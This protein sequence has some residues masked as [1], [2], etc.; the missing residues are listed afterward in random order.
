MKQVCEMFKCNSKTLILFKYFFLIER[1]GLFRKWFIS[2]PIHLLFN[3]GFML[4]CLSIKCKLPSVDVFA[5]N[6]SMLVKA[7][8]WIVKSFIARKW[9]NLIDSFDAKERL[10]YKVFFYQTGNSGV[11]QQ[12]VTSASTTTSS[13]IFST[14][15]Q[16]ICNV[17]LNVNY[18]GN[19]LPGRANVPGP[20]DCCKYPL[21]I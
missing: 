5:I 10:N 19:D 6:T 21:L 18:P 11:K 13:N 8:N 1:C 12:G 3:P 7:T 9:E 15:R 20:G 2:E 17:E 16:F 14:I 4:R